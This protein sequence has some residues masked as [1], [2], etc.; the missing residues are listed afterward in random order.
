MDMYTFS[1]SASPKTCRLL[2]KGIMGV[3]REVVADE[4]TRQSLDLVLTEALAN[5]VR[6]AYAESDDSAGFSGS[7]SSTSSAG[8]HTNPVEVVLAINNGKMIRIDVSD[9]GQGFG[10]CK[11]TATCPTLSEPEEEGGRGLYIMSTLSDEL[12]VWQSDKKN[13]LRMTIK[14]EERKWVR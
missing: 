11:E 12:T 6:H 14:I 5:V 2:T 7:A 9:W 3:L 1:T 8:H 13:T 10:D 4:E